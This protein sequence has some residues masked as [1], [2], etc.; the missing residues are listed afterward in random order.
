V[1]IFRT[2]LRHELI[3]KYIYVHKQTANNF[4]KSLRRYIPALPGKGSKHFLIS[5][6]ATQRCVAGS[7]LPARYGLRGSVLNE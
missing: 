2:F 7:M 5:P 3:V 1:A 4:P 6:R